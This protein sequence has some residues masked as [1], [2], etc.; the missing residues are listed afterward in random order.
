MTTEEA[1][2]ARLNRV[3]AVAWRLHWFPVYA[4]GQSM[5]GQKEVAKCILLALDEGALR[6]CENDAAFGEVFANFRVEMA[7]ERAKKDK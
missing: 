4:Q 3:L 7:A 6:E 2:L 5:M 1:R